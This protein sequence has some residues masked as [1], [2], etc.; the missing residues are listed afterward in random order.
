MGAEHG[1]CLG[2]LRARARARIKSMR[3]RYPESFQ[4][5][6]KA[7]L[8]I[9]T[10]PAHAMNCCPKCD[11]DRLGEEMTLLAHVI[12]KHTSAGF[13]SMHQILTYFL[14]EFIVCV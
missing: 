8:R 1:A 9:L 4:R 6:G 7:V 11:V 14:P 5:M 2:S 13:T 12:E 3:M 10:Y